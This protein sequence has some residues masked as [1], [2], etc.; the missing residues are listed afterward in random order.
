M[1]LN[2]LS[3]LSQKMQI[4]PDM[5]IRE[6]WEMLLLNEL[7][8]SPLGTFLVFKGGTALRLAY[9]SPRF[10]ADLD[11]DL[12]KKIN[13]SDFKKAVDKIV[14]KYPQAKL[15]DLAKKYNTYL[16]QISISEP[17]IPKAFSIKIEISTRQI[18][19]SSYAEL[20][21]LTSP[22][23]PMQILIRVVKLEKITKEKKQALETR[24]QPRDLFDLWYIAQLQRTAW[25]C[26]KHSISAG[27]LNRELK[28]FLPKNFYGIIN[29]LKY[30]K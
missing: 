2:I 7:T 18:R 14:D 10:S 29:N 28:K 16:A 19:E 15:K 23:T 13:F 11:F 3:Q 27:E 17:G 22:T 6:Y 8:Q 5:V 9:N 25:K 20:K 26:P 30:E 24:K 21:I 12:T 4:S 1:E